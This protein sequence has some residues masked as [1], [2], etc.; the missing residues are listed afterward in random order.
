MIGSPARCPASNDSCKASP[1]CPVHRSPSHPNGSCGLPST[2]CCCCCAPPWLQTAHKSSRKPGSSNP[3][4][5]LSD[6]MTKIM[7]HSGQP[8]EASLKAHRSIVWAVA[9]RPNTADS[10]IRHR[11]DD[12]KS[13]AQ[14]AQV[15]N[16]NTTEASCTTFLSVGLGL[17][18]ANMIACCAEVHALY[19]ALDFE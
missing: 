10:I 16:M 13:Q 17:L 4:W 3:G 12:P 6:N 2:C 9:P 15:R 18:V 5:G 19:I 14:P 1:M 7:T 8:D 11:Y